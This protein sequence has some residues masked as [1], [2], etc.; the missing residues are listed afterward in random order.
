[1]SPVGVAAAIVGGTLAVVAAAA[2]VASVGIY[3]GC[4]VEDA[5]QRRNLKRATR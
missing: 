1:M 4:Q 3:V 2:T 5:W